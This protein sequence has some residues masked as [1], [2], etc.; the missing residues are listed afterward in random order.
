VLPRVAAEGTGVTVVLAH[1]ERYPFIQADPGAAA[2]WA[3][4]GA[5]VQ[6][7]AGSV[8]GAYGPVEQRA[9]WELLRRGVATVIASDAHGV[10]RRRPF[11]AD[12]VALVGR[13]LG[14]EAARRLFDDT[15]RRLLEAGLAAGATVA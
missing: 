7:N 14:A 11:W 12:A 6:V 1:A 8:T 10:A 15:P 5:I 4:A 13:Q 2:A 9:A 3:E